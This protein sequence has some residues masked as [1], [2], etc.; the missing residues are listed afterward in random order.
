MYCIYRISFP[1]L[2]F[3]K[4]QLLYLLK[5][6]KKPKAQVIFQPGWVDKYIPKK[7]RE[8]FCG[9][10]VDPDLDWKKIIKDISD[11]GE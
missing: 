8:C 2:I 7:L 4:H 5:E 11:A 10:H 9:P 3:L 1:S 6:C